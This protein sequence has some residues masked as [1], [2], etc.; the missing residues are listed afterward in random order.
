M[1][2]VS[3]GRWPPHGLSALGAAD[4]VVAWA[5]PDWANAAV[6]P[7]LELD[8]DPLAALATP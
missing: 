7:E 8:P 3:S 1:S 2:S 4:G 6:S 5:V